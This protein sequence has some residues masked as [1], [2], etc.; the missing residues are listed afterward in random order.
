MTWSSPL[1]PNGVVSYLLNVSSVNLATG[2]PALL[3]TVRPVTDIN[4]E[5]SVQL[6]VTFEPFV[7]YVVS[8]QAM[9]GGGASMVVRANATSEETG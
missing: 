2:S 9:T 3:Q 7:R 6:E 5:V 1:T 4:P 8:V